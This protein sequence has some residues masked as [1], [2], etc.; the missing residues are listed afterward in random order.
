MW[1]STVTAAIVSVVK[2]TGAPAGTCDASDFILEHATATVNADIPSGNGVGAWTGPTIRF[3]AKAPNPD[4][5]K[6]ATVNLVY[7]IP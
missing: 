4:A 1:V 2:A 5:C 3:N 7:S 6:G